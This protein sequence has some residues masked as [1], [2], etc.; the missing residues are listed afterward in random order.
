MTALARQVEADMGVALPEMA[1]ALFDADSSPDITFVKAQAAAGNQQAAAVAEELALLW[2]E[3]ALAKEASD[4]LTTAL[5]AGSQTEVARLAGAAA[6]TRPDGSAIGLS[7]LV[8]QMG[9]RLETA[10]AGMH[11]L[12]NAARQAVARLDSVMAETD[13]LMTRARNAGIEADPEVTGL[14]AALDAAMQAVSSDPTTDLAAHT[15]K[16]L[17]AARE[18][19]EEVERRQGDLPL[20]VDRLRASLDE[21]AQLNAKAAADLAKSKEKI[22]SPAGL[23]QPPDPDG[24]QVRQL[25]SRVIE[26]EA[27]VRGGAWDK[28]VAAVAAIES[29][30]STLLAE[31][32]RAAKANAAPIARRDELRGQLQIFRA[33]SLAKGLGEQPDLEA[34]HESALRALHVAPCDLRGAEG[35]VRNYI[36]AVNAAATGGTR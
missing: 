21:I 19:I 30:V 29:G 2:Q 25:V 12:A 18:R 13:A 36:A 32:E 4:A 27:D 16:A 17:R 34:L 31:S 26:V 11:S 23:V 28:A 22:A 6:V 3:Y 35:L 5:A 15:D 10:V 8:S 33:K 20:A 14:R 7:A 1:A 9:P 24:A